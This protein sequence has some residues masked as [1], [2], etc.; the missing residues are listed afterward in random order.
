RSQGMSRLCTGKQGRQ[1]PHVRNVL[2]LP[3]Y[4][5]HGLALFARPLRKIRAVLKLGCD[6]REAYRVRRTAFS[7]V[8]AAANRPPVLEPDLKDRGHLVVSRGFGLRM[9][10]EMH[11]RDHVAN[12]GTVGDLVGK[13]SETRLAVEQE[14]GHAELHAELCLEPVLRLM[15]NQRV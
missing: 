4:I 2:Q 7:E 6:L 13:F 12:L 9:H 8:G 5:D 15:M 3:D 14:R 11:A 1:S 10:A